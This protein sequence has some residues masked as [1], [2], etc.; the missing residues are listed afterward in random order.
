MILLYMYIIVSDLPYMYLYRE[1]PG[2]G[3]RLHRYNVKFSD[4]K[5]MIVRTCIG[6]NHK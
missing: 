3:L 6:T 5:L 4:T 1:K 2:F